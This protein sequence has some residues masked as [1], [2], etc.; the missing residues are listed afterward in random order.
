M[1]NA[2]I[3]GG[4]PTLRTTDLYHSSRQ[5]VGLVSYCEVKHFLYRCLFDNTRVTCTLMM[6]GKTQATNLSSLRFGG[7]IDTTPYHRTEWKFEKSAKI[8][9]NHLSQINLKKVQFFNF[10]LTGQFR[11]GWRSEEFKKKN[12]FIFHF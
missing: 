7:S 6:M 5:D 3:W 11:R 8:S 4:H 10:L 9:W 12:S 2:P 1:K